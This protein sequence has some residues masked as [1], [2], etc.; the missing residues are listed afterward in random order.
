M[1]REPIDYANSARQ[2]D[3]IIQGAARRQ[4]AE[5]GPDTRDAARQSPM[6]E[7]FMHELA[8]C[9]NEVIVPPNGQAD[10]GA[11]LIGYRFKKVLEQ[12]GLVIAPM[13]PTEEMERSWKQGWFRRFRN[14][15]Q[16]AMGEPWE[17]DGPLGR[18]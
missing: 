13:E 18:K 15:Y 12:H 1:D 3:E 2:L 5:A 11:I 14:R 17:A 16:A 10:L 6:L 8:R 4:G 7:A 9:C